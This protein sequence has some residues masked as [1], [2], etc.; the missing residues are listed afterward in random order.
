[1]ADDKSRYYQ[2]T[3]T[4]HGGELCIGTVDEEFVEFWSE[5]EAESLAGHIVSSRAPEDD[6][7]FADSPDLIGGEN[8]E[9]YDIDDVLHITAADVGCTARVSEI[10]LHDNA[11]WFN[12]DVV[13]SSG[14]EECDD[15]LWSE[16][17]GDQEINLENIVIGQE[18]YTS[19]TSEADSKPVLQTRTVDR[20]EIFKAIF[21]TGPE[22]FDER[23]LRHSVLETDL[24]DFIERI[25]YGRE[26]LLL[27]PGDTIGKDFGAK[28]GYWNEDSDCRVANEEIAELLDD[29]DNYL[30]NEG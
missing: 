30:M 15:E 24:G 12:G 18:M 3:I 23:L 20:G 5:R 11:E 2:L 17:D 1:M 25:W 26:E 28:V 14:F 7:H 21:R 16:I 19:N 4:G 8:P 22:G 6:R 10:R 9:P 13:W 29:L 27:N